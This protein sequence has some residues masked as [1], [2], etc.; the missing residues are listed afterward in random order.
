MGDIT[1]LS[2]KWRSD[3]DENGQEFSPWLNGLAC[4]KELADALPV[5]IKI[6]DDPATWPESRSD[7]LLQRGKHWALEHQTFFT[8]EF[9][10]FN[11]RPDSKFNR[12]DVPVGGHWRPL[13]SVDYPPEDM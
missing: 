11:E 12:K 7:F 13:C 8:P 5:W 6:T 2:D 3:E 10:P 9:Y 1:K 4:A